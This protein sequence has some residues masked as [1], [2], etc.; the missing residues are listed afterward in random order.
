[1]AREYSD[2]R[3]TEVVEERT[4]RPAVGVERART[5]TADPYDTR[6]DAAAK[7]SGLI[8]L[9][10]GV[11]VALVA[12]R[13]VLLLL[14]AN[15]NAGFSSLIYGITNPLVAPF[16]GIFGGADLG[17]GAVLDPASLVAIV[18]YA[19]AGWLLSRLVWLLMG[20]NRSAVVT[21]S[22]RVDH[23]LP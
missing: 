11:I 19:L 22:S 17:A 1:M 18:V 14:G 15:P 21:R 8:S 5:V 23:D 10:F 3:V 2:E 16:N 12:I 9:V 6:R 7:V 13:F 4:T 20:D